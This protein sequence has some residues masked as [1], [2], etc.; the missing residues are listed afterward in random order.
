[1]LDTLLTT[2]LITLVALSVTTLFLLA[3]MKFWW[4]LFKINELIYILARISMKMDRLGK[5]PTELNPKQK[6]KEFITRLA[7]ESYEN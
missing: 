1:M 4:W 3:T 5:T 2:A 6:W 7:S